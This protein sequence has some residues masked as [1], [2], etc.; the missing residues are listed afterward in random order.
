MGNDTVNRV[1]PSGLD[2]RLVSPPW[3]LSMNPNVT[4]GATL[5]NGGYAFWNQG[6]QTL[7][8]ARRGD[9][10]GFG[11]STGAYFLGMGD[12]VGAAVSPAYTILSRGSDLYYGGPTGARA[13]GRGLDPAAFERGGLVAE[14]DIDVA[15]I[16]F[17]ALAEGRA[18]F[19]ARPPAVR[20][21][22]F[23]GNQGAGP[24][25]VGGAIPKLFNPAEVDPFLDTAMAKVPEGQRFFLIG[26]TQSRLRFAAPK[27]GHKQGLD[28]WP[29][30]MKF[31]P[32]IPEI[33]EL[34][35]IEFNKHLVRRLHEKGFK[36]FDMG[37]DASRLLPGNSAWYQAE[38]EVLK[39]LGVTP[40]K[41][42]PKFPIPNFKPPG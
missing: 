25:Q 12:S 17:P 26:E 5:L 14:A 32:Y 8:Q 38:L 23:P 39:E 30:S 42:I 34:A 40:T 18:A 6:Q 10:R 24:R 7:D 16:L 27:L 41:V 22:V 3:W 33:H 21:L 9:G 28:F 36:F 20:P 2:E 37:A 13:L 11:R 4:M 1:D 35:S 29:E 19:A 31:N 15:S